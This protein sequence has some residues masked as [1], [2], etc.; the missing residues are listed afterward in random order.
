MEI[1]GND[2]RVNKKTSSEK[3]NV[4]KPP[5]GQIPGSTPK[6]TASGGG[7]QVALSSQAQNIQ[8]AIEIAKSAPDIR[9]EKVNRIKAE[10]EDG[11]FKVDSEVL[12]ES[13]LKEILTESQFL[14]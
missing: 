10:I 1:P 7:E 9:M 5:E 6:P 14:E 8:K 11:S 13:I 4:Q 2:F 12:A 3:V